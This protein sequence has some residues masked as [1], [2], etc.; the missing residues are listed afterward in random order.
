MSFVDAAA[1]T[2]A[3]QIER[4]VG[5]HAALLMFRPLITKLGSDSTV[6]VRAT[7]GALRCAARLGD[8]GEVIA[9]ANW[10]SSMPTGPHLD[11]IID[12][13]KA[14]VAQ[15]HTEGAVKLARAET[16]R[17]AT[18]RALYLLARCLD[19]ARD[20]EMIEAYARAAEKAE[21]DA[22]GSAIAVAARVRRIEIFASDPAS[23]PQAIAEA[24]AVSPLPATA[25]QRLVI[26]AAR[27]ASPSRFTR[28]GGLSILE[29]LG[30]K[31]PPAIAE[32]AIRLAAQHADLYGEALSTVEADRL[33]A[34]LRH[35]RD[36]RE[37]DDALARFQAL[38][39]VAGASGEEQERALVEAAE[40]A[41]EI[42]AHLCRARAVLAGGGHGSYAPAQGPGEAPADSP[43]L[44]LAGLG[45]D[46]I[47]ALRRG[48]PAEA[49]SGLVL[50]R[51]T[52]K[53]AVGRVPPPL[54]KGISLAVGAKDEPVRE[55]ALELV[56]AIFGMAAGVPPPHGIGMSLGAGAGPGRLAV[57]LREAGRADLAGRVLRG[58]AAAREPGSAEQLAAELARTGW[59]LFARG[60]RD[61]AIAALREAKQSVD[62][63]SS[64]SGKRGAA[65]G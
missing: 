11:A 1:V 17:E 8:A 18:A 64:T 24:S 42:F 27:L 54:W 47:V 35:W 9:L 50:A 13:C 14:L 58:A 12:L 45:L 36:P 19:S 40:A 37:R 16:E 60:E 23:Y 38:M 39:R 10:W 30:K 32:A 59:T 53:D 21:A 22:S 63:G 2:A 44:R 31:A 6:R 34:A 52:L 29:D 20:P 4:A 28:A 56:E 43:S 33:A 15:R 62:R 48:K 25:A 3:E 61:A 41:P 49:V 57:A 65:K 46:V 55:A 5:A 7:L 26:A 51:E